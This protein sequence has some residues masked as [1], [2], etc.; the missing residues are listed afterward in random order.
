MDAENQAKG[1]EEVVGI[2]MKRGARIAASELSGLKELTKKANDEV[3]ALNVIELGDDDLN[4]S[5]NQ[6]IFSRQSSQVAPVADP[7]GSNVDL[8][9]RSDIRCV[10]VEDEINQT[11]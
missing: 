4:M 9:G 6:L 7:H 1:A 10:N 8:V 11:T 5:P 3:N 2:L